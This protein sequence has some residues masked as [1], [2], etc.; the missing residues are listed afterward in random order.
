ML[1]YMLDTNIAIYTTK[2][3]LPGSVKRSLLTTV[4]CVFQS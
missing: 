3:G 1:K 2:I 4:R